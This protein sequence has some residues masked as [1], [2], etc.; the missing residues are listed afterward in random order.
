M[1]SAGGGAL[2]FAPRSRP[3]SVLLTACP[4]FA[5]GTARYA[6]LR[7]LFLALLG[8]AERMPVLA[9]GEQP[10]LAV[11]QRRDGPR[12][13]RPGGRA[14]CGGA[15]AMCHQEYEH[16][17]YDN[18]SVPPENHVGIDEI[19]IGSDVFGNSR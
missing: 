12:L 14:A 8:A 16:N 13:G 1:C 3:F 6:R 2:R 7:P 11:L 9:T 15:A 18:D 4:L 5:T 17:E 19:N 10:D